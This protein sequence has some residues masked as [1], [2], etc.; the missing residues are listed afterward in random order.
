LQNP[1]RRDHLENSERNGRII[2]KWILNADE[3]I[4]L[5]LEVNGTLVNMV[6]NPWVP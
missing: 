1:K 5:M 2:L 4:Q 3:L 6:L